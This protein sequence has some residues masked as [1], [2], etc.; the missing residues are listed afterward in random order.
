MSDN[1]STGFAAFEWRPGDRCKTATTRDGLTKIRAGTIVQR[2][3]GSLAPS[4]DDEAI[5]ETGLT[6]GQGKGFVGP[7]G[8]GR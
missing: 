7:L 1:D 2:P 3:D 8:S 4:W 6:Y 5:D